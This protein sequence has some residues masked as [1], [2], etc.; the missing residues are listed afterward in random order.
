MV[1]IKLTKGMQKDL[2]GFGATMLGLSGALLIMA[3]SIAILGKMD[4][5]TVLKGG[6]IVT[7]IMGIMVGILASMQNIMQ[8][9]KNAGKIGLLMLGFAGAILII[10]GAIIALSMIEGKDLAKATI[11]V[12]GI[13]VVFAGLLYVSKFAKNVKMGT[14]IGLSIAVAILAASIVALSFIDGKDL[15]Q[16]TI[17]LGAIMGMMS[18]LSYASKFADKKAL[19]GLAGMT[20]IIAGVAYILT[21]MTNGMKDPDSAIKV[22]TALS[23]VI[24]ALSAA[25]AL[26]ATAGKFGKKSLYGIG[27]LAG[28]VGIFG[29]VAGIAIWQLP[30]IADQLSKFMVKLSPFLLG[31]KFIKPDMVESLKILGEAMWAFTKAGSLFAV[32]NV[33]TGGGMGAALSAFKEFIKEAVPIV[34]DIA[35]EVSDMDINIDNLNAIVGAIKTLAEAAGSIASDSAFVAAGGNGKLWGVAA[36]FSKSNLAGFTNFVVSAIPEIQ[37]LSESIKSNYISKTNAEVVKQIV[38]TIG[39]LAEAADAAPTVDILAGFTKFGGG[40]S[41]NWTQYKGFIS[42]IKESTKAIDTFITS[43]RDQKDEKGNITRS[44]I[45]KEEVEVTKLVCECIKILAEAATLVPRNI[46]A[47]IGGGT[48]FK[49]FSGFGAA[50]GAV[51]V[52]PGYDGFINFISQSLTIL[53]RFTRST[54]ELKDSTGAT[55]RQGLTLDQVGLVKTICEGIKLLG[56]A[57]KNV[58]YTVT[59]AGGFGGLTAGLK[60][61]GAGGGGGKLTI[62]P[63]LGDFTTWITDSLNALSAFITTIKDEKGNLSITAKDVEPVI[64]I[65]EAI[66]AIGGAMEFVPTKADFTFG[67]GGAGGG[68]AGGYAFA[69]YGD[70][71]IIPMLTEFKDW[72]VAVLEVLPGFAVNMADAEIT[73]TDI[74]NI[75]S[76]CTAVT[77]LSQ[78][79][80][81]APH[82]I[83]MS[84]LGGALFSYTDVAELTEFKNWIAEIIPLM[85]ELAS[86]TITDADGNTV[87]LEPIDTTKVS[88]LTTLAEAA[89]VI[90][91]AAALA[92][93]KE[94]MSAFFG[95]FQWEESTD[96][97]ATTEWFK[98]VYDMFNGEDGLLKT[99]GEDGIDMSALAKLNELAQ[100]VDLVASAIFMVS[101]A[102]QY[103]FS[104]TQL[105]E[106]VNALQSFQIF[107]EEANIDLELITGASMS[108]KALT[109]VVVQIQ[110]LGD[111]S[112]V[113]ATAFSTK[114]TELAT[115]LSTFQTDMTGIDVSDATTQ[116]TTLANAIGGM[117]YINFNGASS[118][119]T[120]LEKMGKTSIEKFIKT[121]TDAPKKIEKAAQS[122]V[123]TAAKTLGSATNYVRFT[124]AGNYVVEGFAAGI[125]VNTFKA[126]AA[127]AAMADAAYLAAKETLDQNSPS[128]VFMKLARSVPEGFAIGI[129]DEESLVKDAS[130]S[131]AET[132]INSTKKAIARVAEFISSDIDTQPTIR[133]VLD[134]SA[135][136]AGAGAIDGMFD[137]SPRVGAMANIRA[138]NTMMNNRQNGA[139]DDVISAIRE[140]GN[141]MSDMGGDTYNF[142]G[143]SYDDGSNIHS[144][145]QTL[146]RAAKIERRK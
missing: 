53:G 65:C 120:A 14:I 38:E 68:L 141:R 94:E 75:N 139:N 44:K 39:L 85:T 74:D 51:T 143:I 60:K 90:A 12:A 52:L 19:V 1:M 73:Q 97:T 13:G 88:A 107:L 28:V 106:L 7:V 33:L 132:A 67:G 10:T 99:I 40:V 117:S 25:C 72:I 71:S 24:I 80:A 108:L 59:A 140:L 66:K 126:E 134:L 146:V 119:Q 136:S 8:H 111:M 91:G 20:L 5:K 83:D 15:A 102:S 129:Q 46:I 9:A 57:V 41:V 110:N 135:V 2:G 137:M 100:A 3:L 48:L 45:T 55:I 26:V 47:A 98:N 22:A 4:L 70:G 27:V 92:P 115:A 43:T 112:G 18:L 16:A 69:I 128:K 125:T 86:G 37:K 84:L 62:T 118:F 95:A 127:A 133:P 105:Q 142:D 17:A 144:A 35:I 54:T 124:E 61:F 23:E 31:L 34:K 89:K 76:I 103:G 21:S 82:S 56:E 121:F 63:M 114:L 138:I 36:G 32:T 123:N 64:G 131:M 87:T 93:T 130:V 42:F 29:I 79:A 58:P 50:G 145:V 78:A 104:D 116:L 30:N 122:L 109:D 101:S 49:K 113:D 77:T 81:N 6:I 96:L 11:A